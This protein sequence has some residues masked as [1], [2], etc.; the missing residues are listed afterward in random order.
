MGQ[1][2]DDP[3]D[4]IIPARAGFTVTEAMSWMADSGSSPLARGLRASPTAG[5]S[6]WGIIPARAG[7]TWWSGYYEKTDEGSSPLAR[8]LLPEPEEGV[9]LIGIIPA[10][11]GFTLGGRQSHPRNQ[12]HPRSRGVYGPIIGTARPAMG[13]SPLARGLQ[14]GPALCWAGTR[15]IPARAGFT[16]PGHNREGDRRDHPRSR[17]VYSKSFLASTSPSGSSPLARGLHHGRIPRRSAGRIIPARAGF[18]AHHHP[19]PRRPADHPRS[20]GVYGVACARACA[21]GGSSPLARGLRSA[22]PPRGLTP[23]IIPARAGFTRRRRASRSYVWDHPRSRGVYTATASRRRRTPGS[24]PLA[25]GLPTCGIEDADRLRIIPARAGFTPRPRRRHRLFRDHPRSRGVYITR[26]IGPGGS[27]GSSPLARGLRIAVSK[28]TERERIIPARAGFTWTST[29]VRES[30]WDHPR[31]RGVYSTPTTRTSTRNG[32][33]PLAR[34]LRA[35][36][37]ASLG[38]EGIIPA[39]AGFTRGARHPPRDE[40]GSSPLARGLHDEQLRLEERGRIIPAR[41][42]FT[43]PSYKS[44][45]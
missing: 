27:P 38:G 26:T 12:D 4:G 5:R 20:R 41:A 32:S 8:G 37:A 23:R 34:G 22:R 11:A 17:G 3:R 13:S 28:P 35:A 18:T 16:T 30:R 7:F 45:R 33:S 19:R 21:S 36:D 6:S 25:R 14:V 40:R 1:A 39:R 29:A 31:S 43:A 42:G 9:I 44:R 10:R 15:I 2:R 24:S